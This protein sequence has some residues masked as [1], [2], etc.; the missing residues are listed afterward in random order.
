M[1]KLKGKNY[2]G[3]QA[4]IKS[5]DVKTEG[6]IKK[7]TIQGFASTPQID[8]YDD[9]VDPKAFSNALD[10]YM[11]NPV[12]LLG[13]NPDDVIG[14]ATETKVTNKGLYITADITADGSDETDVAINRIEQGKLRT[15]SIGYRP[16][17]I[18][19]QNKETGVELSDQ[20]FFNLPYDQRGGF[21][22]KITELDLV[23]ISVVSTPANPGA[24]FGVEQ[25]IKSFLDEREAAL[26]GKSQ[27]EEEEKELY[28]ITSKDMK[29]KDE[30]KKNAAEV[31]EP[32]KAIEKENEEKGKKK[33]EP[34]K[35]EEKEK[36]EVE[37]ESE[38]AEGE[39]ADDAESAETAGET[40]DKD[41]EGDAEEADADESDDKGA[42]AEEAE[43]AKG[44][45]GSEAEAEETVEASY[46][47]LKSVVQ[48]L[49]NL[50]LESKDAKEDKLVGV[51]IEKLVDLN[52]KKAVVSF[53]KAL[54][55][56]NFKLQKSVTEL[57]TKLAITPD[58]KALV[59]SKHYKSEEEQ[60]AEEKGANGESSDRKASKSYIKS[61]F[62]G[63][64][65]N[66]RD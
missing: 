4:Q 14:L 3:F 50:V 51:K 63:V 46:T 58:K 60:E 16:L 36:E 13:H 66:V 2:F 32:E 64:G 29:K 18:R 38:D 27:I 1:P 23:E 5:V 47:G 55:E 11:T 43:D 65:V 48:T 40:P 59:T 45:E 9:I 15:M 10:T 49:G 57:E 19:F 41:E 39:E 62:A 52:D 7:V 20:E 33:Q 26:S 37:K 17:A 21:L 8:R 54:F 56:L 24:L 35:E 30:Q 6:D 22:R 34:E 42:E 12:I 28:L 61:L 25:S 53:V 44:G 31:A